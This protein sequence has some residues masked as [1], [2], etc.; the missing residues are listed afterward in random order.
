M[1]RKTVHADAARAT[2]LIAGTAKHLA[3]VGQLTL[4]GTS[5]TPAE[6]TTKLQSIVTLRSDV[7]AA[8]AQTQAKLAAVDANM[9]ALRV[10][11]DALVSYVQATF[12]GAPDVLADFGLAS[13]KARTPLT[14]D[15][16]AVSNAKR[17]ATRAA[18]HTMGAQQR[19]AVTGNVAGIV[20]TPLVQ[21]APQ[22][23]ASPASAPP[24]NPSPPAGP[25]GATAAATPHTA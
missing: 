9:P 20:T 22:P 4:A 3:S 1:A 21:P 18:R 16:K 15:A 25:A 11:A 17:A 6:L 7:D 14:V 5:Y 23:L 24:A 8:K 2:Q 19:K 12:G 13:K 10:V